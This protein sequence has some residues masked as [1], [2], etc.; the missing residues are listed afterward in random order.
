MGRNTQDSGELIPTYYLDAVDPRFEY[1]LN[2]AE[3]IIGYQ[4]FDRKGVISL[5]FDDNPF[6]DIDYS[7]LPTDWG[8]IWSKGTF[9]GSCSSGRVSSRPHSTNLVS[10]AVGNDY[11][12]DKTK[13]GSGYAWIQLDSIDEPDPG[14]T[15]IANNDVSLHE[16][17]HALGM[18][19]HFDGFGNGAAFNSNAERV[20]RN[21][22][23]T[24][25]PAGQ[26]F[27]SLNIEP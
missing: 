17:A 18:N 14:C 27:D 24:Q 3:E 6:F 16:L 9:S 13:W 23:S 5:E 12:I 26:P 22:Y 8:F 19:N 4:L 15:T 21:M 1:A 2:K 7:E 10:Y 25:N 20:L 11:G